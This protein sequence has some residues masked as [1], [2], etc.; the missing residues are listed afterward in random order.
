MTNAN[1]M[2]EALIA[3]NVDE[4]LAAKAARAVPDDPATKADIA[5]LKA[6]TKADMTKLGKDIARLESARKV[7]MANL[8]KDIARLE[9]ARKDEINELKVDN[10]K[11]RTEISAAEERGSRRLMFASAALATLIIGAN[12]ALLTLL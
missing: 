10:E 1:T 8:G 4:P 6:T 2:Y 3:A 7:D 12:A 9:L 5:R 11:L